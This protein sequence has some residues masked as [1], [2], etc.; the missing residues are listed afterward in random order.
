[1]RKIGLLSGYGKVPYKRRKIFT[2]T[3]TSYTGKKRI[4]EIKTKRNKRIV[5][6]P[7]YTHPYYH[8]NFFIIKNES[9]MQ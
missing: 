3:Q 9:R 5:R 6:Y 2:Q 4:K 8:N 1:M 7:P